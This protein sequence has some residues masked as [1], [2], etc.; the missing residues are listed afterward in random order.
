M[1]VSKKCQDHKKQ[2]AVKRMDKMQSRGSVNGRRSDLDASQ[3]NG[4]FLSM[5]GAK[6]VQHGNLVKVFVVR[7]A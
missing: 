4:C 5:Y 7:G 2:R 1:K 6:G 3:T